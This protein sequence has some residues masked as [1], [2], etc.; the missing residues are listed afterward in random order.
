MFVPDSTVAAAQSQAKPKPAIATVYRP[1]A[2]SAGHVAFLGTTKPAPTSSPRGS[3]SRRPIGRSVPPLL[4]FQRR[5]A[6]TPAA[7]QP[8]LNPPS[9]PGTAIN[10]D[11][12]GASG[13]SGL[14]DLD[15]LQAGTGAYAGTQI[16]LEPS[17]LGMCVGDGYII[18]GVNDAFAIYRAG[19]PYT[20][21]VAP[22]ANNQFYQ[23]QPET[24][25]GAFTGDF[26]GDPKCYFDPVGQRFIQTI[27]DLSP[28]GRNYVL[29]AVSNTANPAGTW[30]LFSIDVTD[31]GNDGTP[32]HPGCTCYGDQPLIGA[33]QDGLFISTNEFELVPPSQPFA[34][35]QIYAVGFRSLEAA[36]SGTLP[37]FV[38]I[39]VS[40]QVPTDDPN[41]P[42]WGSIQPSTSPT[43]SSGTE[44]FMSGGPWNSAGEMAPLDDRIGVWSLSGTGSLNTASPRLTLHQQVLTSET[45]GLALNFGATQKAGPTPLRDAHGDVDPIETLNADDAR[46]NQVMLA[47]GMLY[48]ALS[49]VVTASGQPDRVGVAYFTIDPGLGADGNLSARIASQ[50]YIAAA[51]ES[52]LY[53]SIAK[54]A[55]GTGV[56]TF[57]LTGPDYFPSAAYIQFN[58]QGPSGQIHLVGAG[59]A[60]EDGATGYAFHGGDG[61]ARWG[62][63]TAAVG[64]D[65]TLFM[66][67]G[68]IPPGPR[69]TLGNWGTFVMSQP[70][71]NSG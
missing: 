23:R 21:V 30:N 9:P 44:L 8:S 17:D 67:A 62:D 37:P 15:Q 50:G 56:M 59:A 19:A 47:D 49:T 33:N 24:T 26:L 54:T 34:G 66:A 61:V 36:P 12:G 32:S 55:L 2:G 69:A 18:E 1:A 45:F 3:A 14:N 43:P 48:G 16:S 58:G 35:S 53:P 7:A 22:T 25:G 13:F 31:D 6:A 70:P 65:R 40:A 29:V 28:S 5:H 46:M 63:Y 41:F 68:Y 51:G 10:T 71:A 64:V 20:Q 38:H 11:L 42:L 39:N 57:T 60:P 27:V 4:R 52:L